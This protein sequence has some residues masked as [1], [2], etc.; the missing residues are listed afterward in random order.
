MDLHSVILLTI[1]TQGVV[2]ELLMDEYM[3]CDRIFKNQR[4]ARLL[5]QIPCDMTKQ[6]YCNF[7]GVAYPEAS[8]WRFKEENRA[9]MRRL[10]GDME[11]TSVYREMRATTS[12]YKSDVKSPILVPG[13]HRTAAAA[14]ADLLPRSQYKIRVGSGRTKI[15]SEQD[16]Q[17]SSGRIAGSLKIKRRLVKK[18]KKL[19]PS[20]VKTS[21]TK[22]TSSVTVSATT[23]GPS[24]PSYTTTTMGQPEATTTEAAGSTTTEAIVPTT[25]IPPPSDTTANTISPHNDEDDDDATEA[26]TTVT[27]TLD[28]TTLT[29]AM[30]TVDFPSDETTTLDSW[31]DAN[32]TND[33]IDNVTESVEAP[34]LFSDIFITGDEPLMTSRLGDGIDVSDDVT[35]VLGDVTSPTLDSTLSDLLADVDLD[36]LE[37]IMGELLPEAASSIASDLKTDKGDDTED[38]LEYELIEEDDDENANQPP[39]DL[40]P[41]HETEE[42]QYFGNSVNACP[43]KEEVWAPY[44]ANNT[45]GQTLAL[46]NIY[47]FEQYVHMEVCK[48]EHKQMLCKKGCKCEQQYGLHRLLAFDPN[49]E[50]RGIFSDWFKFPS[51]CICKCYN[52]PENWYEELMEETESETEDEEELVS[53]RTTKVLRFPD[54][55]GA[56]V[57]IR[58]IPAFLP[59]EAKQAL[60]KEIR[61]HRRHRGLDLQQNKETEKKAK[62]VTTADEAAVIGN[63]RKVRANY[64][65]VEAPRELSQ[66]SQHFLYGQVPIMGYK[67]ADGSS[68]SV[69]QVPRK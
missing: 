40:E 51:L 13:D 63:Q 23:S 42:D 20:I 60:L 19:N 67:L 31:A 24:T 15:K 56:E 10:Y 16:E 18:K 59:Y 8:I 61:D 69:K 32:N 35:G 21:T 49:N 5:D 33:V 45:K 11:S 57:N 14:A 47:P 62:K 30:T 2:S 12:S 17:K 52:H 25:V 58:N 44:W 54:L 65:Q 38:Y 50:C 27:S 55:N 36:S 34:T 37:Q 22:S 68:G 48:F 64:P 9:L 26:T 3:S 6:T 4:T 46:M 1:I 53:S 28:E 29:T 39:E 66:R 7:K 41:V 43:V